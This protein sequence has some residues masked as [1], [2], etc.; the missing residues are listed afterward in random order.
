MHYALTSGYP[1][2][3][4]LP[5]GAS[6]LDAPSAWNLDRSACP[7]WEMAMA[8]V[9]KSRKAIRETISIESSVRFPSGGGTDVTV[10]VNGAE[11]SWWSPSRVDACSRARYADH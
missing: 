4:Y 9:A 2:D 11:Q 7:G 1:T 10:I 6:I 5:A 8:K 3:G